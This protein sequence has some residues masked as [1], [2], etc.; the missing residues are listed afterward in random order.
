M[1]KVVLKE[2]IGRRRVKS[3]GKFPFPALLKQPGMHSLG[4]EKQTSR[5]AVGGGSGVEDWRSDAV[6]DP[7][8]LLPRS[9][10]MVTKSHC[11][12]AS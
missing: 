5:A 1:G 4:M 6:F 9:Q 12:C 7:P 8:G 11:I 3:W 2:E 10:S